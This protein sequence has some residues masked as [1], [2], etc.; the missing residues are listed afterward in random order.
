MLIWG[1]KRERSFCE[2]GLTGWYVTS[3]CTVLL[4][5]VVMCVF[6]NDRTQSYIS[7][8]QR[9]L[10]ETCY[11][12]HGGSWLREAVSI[13]PGMS[14]KQPTVMYPAFLTTAYLTVEV[15]QHPETTLEATPTT[16]QWRP[17]GPCYSYMLVLTS[18]IHELRQEAIFLQDLKGLGRHSPSCHQCPDG[19]RKEGAA[20]PDRRLITGG[21]RTTETYLSSLGSFPTRPKAD[22][23]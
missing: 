23:R 1:G 10:N 8:S 18:D 21:P 7:G 11:G 17:R 16:T 12:A 14:K 13:Y 22:V 9:T 19:P 20:S 2:V 15:D 5:H 6:G 3:F 4:K